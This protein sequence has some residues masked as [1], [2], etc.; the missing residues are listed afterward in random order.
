LA[1]GQTAAKDYRYPA[2]I[3]H[4]REC[5]DD[6]A[7]GFLQ[8]AGTVFTSGLERDDSVKLPLNSSI[9]AVYISSP[10]SRASRYRFS[11]PAIG[12]SVVVFPGT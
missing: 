8:Y 10:V 4:Y 12:K 6:G 11:R 9:V 3:A 2:A 7:T 1:A 5:S